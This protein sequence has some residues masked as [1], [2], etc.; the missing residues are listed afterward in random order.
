MLT[1]INQMTK[2][3]APKVPTLKSLINHL[4]NFT[5]PNRATPTVKTKAQEV[6]PINGLGKP[7]RLP[8]HEFKLAP[9]WT[10]RLISQATTA[11]GFSNFLIFST[12]KENA[13]IHPITADKISVIGYKRCF[14]SGTILIL[15][16]IHSQLL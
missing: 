3:R 8:C 1:Y 14:S 16:A 13:A 12:V 9:H 7:K 15:S 11:S 4:G 6:N 5:P 10:K 2:N